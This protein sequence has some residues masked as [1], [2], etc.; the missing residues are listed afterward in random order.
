[1]FRLC[2]TDRPVIATD[3]RAVDCVEHSGVAQL[4]CR[5]GKAASSTNYLDRVIYC[6]TRVIEGIRRGSGIS[7]KYCV[8]ILSYPMVADSNRLPRH[9]R[10]EHVNSNSALEIASDGAECCGIEFHGCAVIKGD[11]QFH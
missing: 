6:F 2:E 3:S 7:H 9:E 4:P 8:T 11:Y 5:A 10:A 1:V